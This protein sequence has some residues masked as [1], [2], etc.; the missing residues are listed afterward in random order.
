VA[1]KLLAHIAAEDQSPPEV[2]NLGSLDFLG[3]RV[4]HRG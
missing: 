3:P 1:I 2:N 4:R